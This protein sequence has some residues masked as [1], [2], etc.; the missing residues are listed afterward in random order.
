VKVFGEDL[1]VG[2]V[3]VRFGKTKTVSFVGTNPRGNFIRVE[4]AGEPRK[5]GDAIKKSWEFDVERPGEE[6]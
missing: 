6:S 1:K 2:D 4:Y 3:I 5:H